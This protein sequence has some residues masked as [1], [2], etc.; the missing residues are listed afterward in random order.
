MHGDGNDP[1]LVYRTTVDAL[2]SIRSGS[3]P[4]F[5]E[6]TTYRYREHCGPNFDNDI[7]YRT[8][9]EFLRW[10]AADPVEAYERRLLDLGTVTSEAV[11]DMRAEIAAEVADA[12]AFAEHSAF[13]D[14]AE[15][16]CDLYA[17]EDGT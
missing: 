15:A 13:P 8:E 17:G 9:A 3:G 16:Y 14:A 10:R 4:A 2:D 6:F 1:E 7:G 11:R 5:V 12:F